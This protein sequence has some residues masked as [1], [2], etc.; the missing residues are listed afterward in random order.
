[1]RFFNIHYECNDARDD[2]SKLLKQQHGTN[3]I[4]PHWFRADENDNFDG[5]NFVDGG[6]FPV[7]EEHEADQYTFVGKKSQQK[8]EQMGEIQ[9]IVT[10]AGWLD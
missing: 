5:D 2:Y 6:D 1:M 8:L 4:F 7:H 3:G 9:K 10:S